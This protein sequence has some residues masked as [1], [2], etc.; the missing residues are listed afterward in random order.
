MEYETRALKIMVLPKGETIF[1]EHATQIEIVDDASGEY[2]KVS[3]H[4]DHAENGQIC[5]DPDQWPM[6]SDAITDMISECRA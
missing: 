1:Y 2:V 3:Q 4:N 6:L 5:I